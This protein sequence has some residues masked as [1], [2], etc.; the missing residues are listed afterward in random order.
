MASNYVSFDV[1]IDNDD[2]TTTPLS[3]QTVHV[4]DVT[5]DEALDD[6][7]SGSTGVVAAGSLDVDA[8]TLIRFHFQR[9]DG[10]C[11]Y[12]EQITTA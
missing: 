1:K 7:T 9:D 4:Y 3:L 2:G 5:N 8:G 10:I 6:V 12:A 11:G